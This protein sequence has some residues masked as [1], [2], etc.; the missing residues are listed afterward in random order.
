[1]KGGIGISRFFV[2]M[3]YGEKCWVEERNPTYTEN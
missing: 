2:L 3:E 1:M